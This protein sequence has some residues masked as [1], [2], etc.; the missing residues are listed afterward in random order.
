M[1]DIHNTKPKEIIEG[2]H[3]RFVHTKNNTL[4]WWEV[5]KGA[6]LPRHSHEHEQV[7]QVLEGRFQLTVA[8]DTFICE[9]GQVKIIPPHIEHEGVALTDCKIFDLLAPSRP[10][11]QNDED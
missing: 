2:F 3:G 8:N 7:T 4:A 11:Y 6:V 9:P 10:E 5:K 1:I